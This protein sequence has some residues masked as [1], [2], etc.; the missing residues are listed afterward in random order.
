M[1]EM[2]DAN[3]TKI[4]FIDGGVPFE[5][6]FPGQGKHSATYPAFDESDHGLRVAALAAGISAE[7]KYCGV[8][9]NSFLHGCSKNILYSGNLT[10]SLLDFNDE[11]GGIDVLCLAW[12]ST[13][14]MKRIEAERG[15]FE[16][17][18]RNGVLVVAATGHDG[19]LGVRFPALLP[20]VLAVGVYSS[21]LTM[22]DRVGLSPSL[23]KPTLSI[24]DAHYEATSFGKA[25][26]LS[27]TS[28]A[29][30]ILSG[31]LALI[32]SQLKLRG[33]CDP[34]ADLAILL[35]AAAEWKGPGHVLKPG[36]I[37]ISGYNVSAFAAEPS[38]KHTYNAIFPDDG[39][40]VVSIALH[41]PGC[42]T[43]GVYHGN[44]AVINIRTDIHEELHQCKQ[45]LFRKQIIG[46][47]GSTASIEISVTTAFSFGA[48]AVNSKFGINRKTSMA[49][50]NK[51]YTIGI[52][53]SHNSAACITDN[54]SI[55]TAIQL[56][57]LSRLKHDGE[58]SLTSKQAIEYCLKSQ[59]IGHDGIHTWGFNLQALLPGWTGLS[60]PVHRSDFQ[61]FDP[62]SSN[63]VYISHH[64]AHAF[65]AF[66][67]CPFDNAVVM[68]ADGSGGSVAGEEDDLLIYGS[69]LSDYLK[70][71]VKRRPE[72]DVISIYEF[73]TRNFR[74]LHREKAESFNVRAGSSSLGE[75]YAS[76]SNYVFGDWI[77]GSGKLMGLA[78]YGDATKYASFLENGEDGLVNFG[79]R[80]KLDHNLPRSSDVMRHS[81]LAARV[82][83]DVEI[84]LMQRVSLAAKKSSCKNFVF[85]GGLALNC[86]AN[87]K[88]KEAKNFDG[89]FF[90]PASNDAGIAIGSAVGACFHRDG[91]VS[92]KYSRKFHWS[93]F[94]G[95]DYQSDDCSA[96]IHGY[97]DVI[98]K[99]E[100][101]IQ[102]II[103]RLLDGQVIGLFQGKS[104]FGP[105]ALG[106]RSLIA[107]PRDRQIWNHIN[108]TVKGREDFR[109]FAPVVL[110]CDAPTYFE[111]ADASPFML[112]VVKVR[113]HYRD[114]LGA[115]THVDGTARVQ[116]IS[117]SSS[118]TLAEL[119]KELKRRGLPP[120]LLNTSLNFSGE[121][122]VETPAEAVEFLLMRPIA[123]MILNDMFVWRK[124]SPSITSKSI[125]G[126]GVNVTAQITR[127]RAGLKMALKRAR[128]AEEYQFP[129]EIGRALICLD[130]VHSL[131]EVCRNADTVLNERLTQILRSLEAKGFTLYQGERL[132]G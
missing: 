31:C 55:L 115:V 124:K 6:H 88:L 89:Y 51:K 69:Q 108:R 74:L 97:N 42:D 17:L 1:A 25:Y 59:R 90:F 28:A 19:S 122:I 54:T 35:Q 77:D 30:A 12:S 125:F 114:I 58:K 24:E 112:R 52:S 130:G 45:R 62:F 118:E 23:T 21:E 15:A 71:E 109:P 37:N 76:V 98:E 3:P 79:Q 72:V 64:L 113:D 18:S 126:L 110:D 44:D 2:K 10:K 91:I 65:A 36:G 40:L 14:D 128:P 82:Q 46:R 5:S 32:R 9:P 80:W 13:P 67:A 73:S 33:V 102:N 121:P 43:H 106:H 84:A 100:V 63:A 111:M 7:A 107:I 95:Y 29:A 38:I 4:A 123:G 39:L 94:L 16:E 41:G 105:R 11:V 101:D 83:A 103:N 60:Q 22:L 49:N 104:E 57:R 131:E 86:V 85:T 116:T 27:G 26:S 56:E 120:V 92:P 99:G 50:N 53:Q 81:D 78:P 96:A 68:V 132:D 8:S 66:A 48:V 87:E 119:L 117:E 61:V 70:K 127:S 75:T 129:M 47:P 20:D 34:A 93:E